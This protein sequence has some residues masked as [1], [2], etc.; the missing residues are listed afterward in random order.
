MVFQEVIMDITIENGCVKI[1]DK[2][3]NVVIFERN[4]CSQ[5][6]LEYIIKY[7]GAYRKK[8]FFGLVEDKWKLPDSF[9]FKMKTEL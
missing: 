8:R 5:H 7:V 2:E 4:G 9:D 1:F 6:E 3:L